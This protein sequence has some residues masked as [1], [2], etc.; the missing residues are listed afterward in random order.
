MSYEKQTW[1][2]G[3]LITADKLNHIEDGIANINKIQKARITFRNSGPENSSYTIFGLVT[4]T[5]DVPEIAFEGIE[6]ST[7]LEVD[8]PLTSKYTTIDTSQFDN[9]NS[10]N[11]PELEGAVALAAPGKFLITGDCMISLTGVANV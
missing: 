8:V 1:V 9:I 11:L 3:D 2:D 7:E 4:L 10:Q 6:V 5:N